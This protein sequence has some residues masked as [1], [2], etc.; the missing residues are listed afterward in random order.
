MVTRRT[1]LGSLLS[2]AL[3]VTSGCQARRWT[4]REPGPMTEPPDSRTT[5]PT[6][7]D[8]PDTAT[9]QTDTQRAT[10][11]R[12]PPP[13]DGSGPRL[14]IDNGTGES[15]AVTA[16]VDP[17]DSTSVSNSWTLDPTSSIEEETFPPLDNSA[18]VTVS[19]DGYDSVEYDWIG[20][21]RTLSVVVRT[22]EIDVRT[23][24]S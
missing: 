10:E 8:E 17:D 11:T 18:S 16:E 13:T 9:E 2:S 24:V 22:D 23:L 1:C 21:D 4:D 6:T 14:V 19:T 3:A 12:T 5:D 7:T 15:R 20:A